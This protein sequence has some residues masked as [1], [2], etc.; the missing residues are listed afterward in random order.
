VL[1]SPL[2]DQLVPLA[3]FE[4]KKLPAD[5]VAAL[6]VT[7][8]YEEFEVN[9]LDGSVTDEDIEDMLMV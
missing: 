3:P 6:T 7:L 2:W 4:V 5:P 8:P 1:E 9:Q